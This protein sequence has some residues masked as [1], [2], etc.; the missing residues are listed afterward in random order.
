[1]SSNATEDANT[2]ASATPPTADGA[3][4]DR[5]DE[6]CTDDGGTSVAA[7]TATTEDIAM[8]TEAPTAS[9]TTVVESDAAGLFLFGARFFFELCTALDVSTPHDCSVY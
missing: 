1:M 2:D 4:D 8:G 3:T 6:V 9:A 5:A 7:C